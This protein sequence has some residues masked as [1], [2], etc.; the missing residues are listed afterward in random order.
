MTDIPLPTVGAS[1]YY[2]LRSPLNTLVTL[3]ERYTC[4]A[5]RRL[6]DY[7]AN[8]EDAKTD[9]YVKVGIE[10]SYDQDLNDNVYIVSLQ[11]DKGHWLYVPASYI[12]SYPLTNGIPYRALM[13]GVS[14]PSIPAD[15]DLSF[16]ETDIANL[17]S[18]VLGVVPI[19]RQVETS[20]VVLV[21]KTK[22]DLLQA[23][24]NALSAGRVTDRAR[25]MKTQQDLDTALAKIAALEQYI[26]NHL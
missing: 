1:G 17:V 4:Q 3:G 10:A 11:S 8:N 19:M 24:R 23:E 16:L 6:S 7:L 12:V 14:L 15:R 18:D 9:I 22:H 21:T 2:E 25:Y 20:R 13:I 26:K 5:I